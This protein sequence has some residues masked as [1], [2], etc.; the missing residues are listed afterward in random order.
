M[1]LIDANLLL[2]AYH[3]ESPEY[4]RASTWL[5]SVLSGTDR[6]LLA[7]PTFGRAFR[8]W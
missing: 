1:I 5:E 2:Y 6:E 8:P 3:P 4:E 7:D